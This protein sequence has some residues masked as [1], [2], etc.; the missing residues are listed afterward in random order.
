MSVDERGAPAPVLGEKTTMGGLY[1]ADAVA[2]MIRSG[3]RLLLAGDE[4]LLAGLPT[5]DWIGGTI[6]Y[7]MVAEGG[8]HT[9]RHI[10]VTDLPAE[11][12]TVIRRY[13]T[14]SLKLL[15]ADHPGHGFTVLLIPAFS[16]AHAEYARN[17]PYYAGIFE[18]PVVGWVSGVGLDDIGR[19]K[20]KV[21]DGAT[22]TASTD[23]AVAVHVSVPASQRVDVDIINLFEP[24]TGDAIEFPHGGFSATEA[25]VNGTPT[26]FAHYL[27][28]QGTDTRLPLVANYNGAMVNVSIQ[29]VDAAGGRVD[30]YA[31]VFPDVTYHVAKPVGDYVRAFA[32]QVPKDGAPLSFSCNCVL[33]YMY[34]GLEGKSIGP[35]TGPMTF[36]EIAFMLLNQTAVYV[37]I[38]PAG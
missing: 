35:L 6:P 33:N 15:A 37:T 5:G 29:Q 8:L 34:A 31:P 28:G 17:M 36:G 14:E 23:E 9:A 18:R 19:I 16:D 7:F 10:F 12:A 38:R 24:G 20:P 27:K 26:G 11:S 1:S 25:L 22:G 21:F 30:F 13:T 4:A 3:R 32:A 2:G